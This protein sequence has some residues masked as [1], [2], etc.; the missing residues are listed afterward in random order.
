MKNTSLT[1]E[2]YIRALAEAKFWLPHL[3]DEVFHIDDMWVHL[4]NNW[5]MFV[6]GVEGVATLYPV[7]KYGADIEKGGFKIFEWRPKGYRNFN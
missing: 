1:N 7:N 2:I 3:V 4:S 6:D 5:E